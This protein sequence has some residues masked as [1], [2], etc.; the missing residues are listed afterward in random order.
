M[1]LA[2]GDNPKA[3]QDAAVTTTPAALPSQVCNQAIIQADP[4]N[5]DNVLLGDSS[6]QYYVLQAGKAIALPCSNV[7]QLYRK[8]ASGTQKVNILAIQ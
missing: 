1:S 7:N 6:N 2:T 3:L 4:G 5:T 8:S